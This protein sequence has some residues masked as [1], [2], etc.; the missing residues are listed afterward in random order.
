MTNTCTSGTTSTD[1]ET[2]V[3]QEWTNHF[4]SLTHICIAYNSIGRLR[5][6]ETCAENAIPNPSSPPT[7][8]SATA[9]FVAHHYSSF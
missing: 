1:K 3:I 2:S 4:K 5:S 7:D 8:L 6:R 9:V